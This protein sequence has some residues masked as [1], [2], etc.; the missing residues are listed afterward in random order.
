VGVRIFEEGIGR[1]TGLVVAVVEERV[2][3]VGLGRGGR[4]GVVG[5]RTMFYGGMSGRRF[6]VDRGLRI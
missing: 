3:G 2:I 5:D 6:S 1:K 4:R